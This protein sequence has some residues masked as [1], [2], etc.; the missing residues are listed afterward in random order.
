MVRKVE[1]RTGRT[2]RTRDAYIYS[3]SFERF[4]KGTSPRS[5]PGVKML[6]NLVL[7]KGLTPRAGG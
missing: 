5:S 2:L 3:F 6:S 4:S 7:P 1:R